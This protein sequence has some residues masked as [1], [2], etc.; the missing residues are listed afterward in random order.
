[1]N[2][3]VLSDGVGATEPSCIVKPVVV[4]P[5]WMAWALSR[6]GRSSGS[7]TGPCSGVG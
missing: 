5:G 3:W 2:C 4:W 1:M 7:P 6:P